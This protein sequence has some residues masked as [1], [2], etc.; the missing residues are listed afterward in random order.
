MSAP[1]MENRTVL[2]ARNISK[3]YG[4][5]RA[6]NDVSLE[7]RSGEIVGLVGENG[8]GKSTLLRML[9]GVDSAD[10]G[11]IRVGDTNVPTAGLAGSAPLGIGVVFQELALI[12]NLT[13]FENFFLLA[14]RLGFKFGMLRRSSLREDCREACIRYG[15]DCDPEALVAELPFDQR[16]MLEIVR[17]LELPRI[18]GAPCSILLLDEPTTA[19]GYT[20]VERLM[21]M[22]RSARAGGAAVVFVSHRLAEN[23]ALADRLVVLR[24][25]TLVAD[26]APE[27]TTERELHKLMVGR[28]RSDDYYHENQRGQIHD[29]PALELDGISGDGFQHVELSVRAGEIVGLAGLASSGKSQLCE[30]VHGLQPTT[31]GRTRVCGADVTGKSVHARVDLGVAFVPKE[32][33]VAGIIESASIRATAGLQLLQR[34][35]FV[36]RTE[37]SRASA[38]VIERFRVKARSVDAPLGTLSGGNQQ[39]VALGKW[40]VNQPRLWILDNPTRGVD[41]G[42]RTEI[43]SAIREASTGGAGILMA[44]D[45][46]NEL[47]GMCD[48]IFVM[49]DG[50]IRAEVNPG[51]GSHGPHEV[52]HEIVGYMV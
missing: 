21:K 7:L 45:E 35:L 48:R 36:D 26:K 9:A 46:I 18:L 1:V 20:S 22:L 44:S 6:L 33:L 49:R 13:V 4:G 39:K 47:I 17:A 38:E 19:L 11:T 51:A 32:R 16:Q 10:S 34:S 30:A 8:S 41:V 40:L 14:P 12:S 27:G 50:E 23:L 5:T 31:S 43:Y 15:L 52:E 37:E 24:D 3:T 2:D 29:Q 28:E 42:A 25:G